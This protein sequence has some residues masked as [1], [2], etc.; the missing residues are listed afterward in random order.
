MSTPSQAMQRHQQLKLEIEDHNTAYHSFDAPKISDAEYD[1]LMRELQALEAQYPDLQ[2]PDSP[3]QRV[4]AAPL[5]EFRQIKHELAM[6]SLSN[7]FSDQ[8]IRAFDKRLHKQ[9]ETDESLSFTYVAEPK[10]DGLAVSIMYKDGALAYAAT[11]GDGKVGEDITQ[12]VKTIRSIPLSL[13]AGAPAQLEVRGEVFISH[14]GFAK[15]NESQRSNNKKEFVNPRN[16]AAGSLRQLDSKITAARNLSIFIYS[17]GV[18][19]DTEF[20]ETHFEMLG[21]IGQTWFPYL[22]FD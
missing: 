12:N 7:G 5:D 11:R 8:D 2:S 17:V 21:C 16:A 15:L 9:L 19:S 6:L 18:I 20:A 10:L 3:S 22:S 14:R 13:P 1:L 4:G